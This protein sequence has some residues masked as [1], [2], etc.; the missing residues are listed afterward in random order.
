MSTVTP[1]LPPPR[2]TIAG[3]DPDRGHWWNEAD[4]RAYGDARE[5]AARGGDA[6]LP[7]LPEPV[8]HIYPSDLERFRTSETTASAFSVAVGNP[9]TGEHS[10]ALCTIDEARTYGEACARAAI[11]GAAEPVALDSVPFL[12]YFDDYERRPEVIIGEAA[13]RERFRQVSASWNAHLFVK[14]ASNT[15][16]DT[17]A[18]ANAVLASPPPPTQAPSQPPVDEPVPSPSDVHLAQAQGQAPAA[19]RQ[20]SHQAYLD[21]KRRLHGVGPSHAV[22]V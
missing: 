7:E 22:S 11:A 1:S 9:D 6:R 16:D 3:N 8:A 5:R 21:A 13:A 14:V 20:S 15:R 2:M 19:P 12:V 4:L 17:Y 10:V 18:K